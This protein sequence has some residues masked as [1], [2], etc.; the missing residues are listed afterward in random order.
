M[1]GARLGFTARIPSASHQLLIADDRGDHDHR[2]SPRVGRL[3]A[4]S[5][6]QPSR[7][8]H[9]TFGRTR[10][11]VGDA[12]RRRFGEE[13]ALTAALSGAVGDHLEQLRESLGRVFAPAPRDR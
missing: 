12:E 11:D 1:Q 4:H 6:E 10:D 7:V 2:A 3:D 13:R 5:L 9:A 8:R